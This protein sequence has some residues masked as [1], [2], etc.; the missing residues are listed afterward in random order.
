MTVQEAVGFVHRHLFLLMAAAVLGLIGAL[1]LSMLSTPTYIARGQLMLGAAS[2][3]NVS[4]TEQAYDLAR[5]QISSYAELANSPLILQPV[6]ENL[7]LDATPAELAGRVDADYEPG[8]VIVNLEAEAASPDEAGRV[9]QMVGTELTAAIESL[10]RLPDDQ[11]VL[12]AV[13]LTPVLADST[14]AGPSL[15]ERLFI[16]AFGG[17][18]IGLVL[19]VFR[20]ALRKR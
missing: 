14:P 16:G 2:D 6:I 15:A 10:D 8:S 4:D 7:Q 5:G 20:E 12:T 18:L 1:A 17:L 9:V 19:A 3:A 13:S 11:P